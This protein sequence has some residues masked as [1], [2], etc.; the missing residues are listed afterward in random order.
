MTS[1]V[2][3]QILPNVGSTEEVVRIVDEV[4][5]YI[6][7]TG[8]NYYVGPFETTIEGESYDQLMEIVANCS[9]VAVN[10]GAPSVSAY[11]RVSYKPA[12][13]ILTIDEKIGKYNK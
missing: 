3:I 8:L 6:A 10:A 12:G 4:I 5:A 11:V 2:A 9:K 1:S 7:S 13:G